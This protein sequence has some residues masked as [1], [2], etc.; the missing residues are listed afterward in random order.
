L[1]TLDIVNSELRSPTGQQHIG[2]VVDL[3]EADG[4]II[5]TRCARIPA[6]PLINFAK[7]NKEVE[8]I[9][10][11]NPRPQIHGEISVAGTVRIEAEGLNLTR[12]SRV[13]MHI[14]RTCN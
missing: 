7:S 5:G 9:H 13:D 11:I 3:K 2:L 14:E 4:T 6:E 10:G 8:S 12:V 1:S